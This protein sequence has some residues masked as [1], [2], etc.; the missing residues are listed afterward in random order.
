MI[1][2]NFKNNISKVQNLSPVIQNIY[3]SENDID[4]ESIMELFLYKIRTVEFREPLIFRNQSQKE[5]EVKFTHV[6][7]S[8][9]N[10]I[11]S[12][13]HEVYNSRKAFKKESLISE[14][15]FYK[16]ILNILTSPR[17]FTLPP[18]QYEAK[19]ADPSISQ[20]RNEFIGFAEE[21]KAVQKNTDILIVDG[22]NKNK[23]K[24]KDSYKT[25]P[26]QR[27]TYSL[28]V[29]YVIKPFRRSAVT[30][31]DGKIVNSSDDE[32]LRI[33]AGVSIHLKPIILADDRPIW[34]LKNDELKSRISIFAGLSFPKPLYN[35]HIGIGADIWTGIKLTTGFHFY[36]FTD[37]S[38]LNGQ[39]IDQ[40]SKYVFNGPF[41]G[42][43]IDPVTFVKLLTSSIFK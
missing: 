16:S 2:R 15:I 27:V 29:C 20:F 10:K 7:D 28:G 30:I 17:F 25:A 11:R 4:C 33:I 6:K 32:Q 41:V 1:L 31:Q 14:I 21:K 37:Y 9:L 43:N 39:I 42:L 34:K 22:N 35:P 38:I 13:A 3:A 5:I 36:R 8:I 24:V 40:H 18:K 23:F 26:E 12:I 19:D